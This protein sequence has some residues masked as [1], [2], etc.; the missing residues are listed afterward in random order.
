[1]NKA[2]IATERDSSNQTKTLQNEKNE[3]I[4][5]FLYEKLC[6]ETVNELEWSDG[7][8]DPVVPKELN[9]RSGFIQL[10]RINDIQRINKF[11]EAVNR[12]MENGQ[13]F[14]IAMETKNSRK[15]RIL[16]KFPKLVSKPYYVLD[17]VLKR[18]FPK[19]KPTRKLYFKITNGR[20]RVLSRS[21]ALARMICCGYEIIGYKKLEYKTY[22]IGKKVREPAY[23]MQPTYGALVRLD[24]VGKGRKIIKVCKMRT[25][26][27]Y[28]EY[29][30]DYIYKKYNLEEGGKFSNDFRMTSWGKFFRKYWIDELPM[31]INYFRGEM[32][33]VGVRPLSRQYFELYPKEL[34]ELRT[35]V[36]PGLV[37]PY[38]ADMPKGLEEI[39]ESEREYLEAY[40]EKPIRTD[41]RY[42]FTSFY[43]ILFKGAR[44]G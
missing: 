36:K 29:L 44:S 38:Y 18:V 43:N 19:W 2:V 22:I 28:S 5:E 12:K 20:N 33:L 41:I 23:D 21:E 26:Y 25:M 15:E 37:P 30:Q 17:F 27:P 24:R 16:N 11:M 34:Q 10:K 6:A 4:R 31:F 40:L 8:K 1:M 13:Y 7:K 9:G 39:Q 3:A 35:C 32:K 42:F 14:V